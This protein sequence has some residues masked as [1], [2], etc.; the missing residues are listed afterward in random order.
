MDEEERRKRVERLMLLVS[1]FSHIK[2]IFFSVK[3]TTTFY[4]MYVNV[5]VT[6]LFLSISLFRI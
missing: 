1:V 3:I 5:N 4:E 2:S 6:F